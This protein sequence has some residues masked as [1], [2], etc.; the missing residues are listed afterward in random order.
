MVFSAYFGKNQHMAAWQAVMH[1]HAAWLGLVARIET[2]RLPHG[3]ICS[4]GWLQSRMVANNPA[5]RETQ[6]YLIIPTWGGITAEAR[7][8]AVE[9]TRQQLIAA[10]RSNVIQFGLSL[11]SGE[12]MVAVPPATPEQ[13]YYS[14][15]HRGWVFSNDMR[16]M[17][18]WAV[19]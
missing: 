12:L 5:L 1:R 10:M 11:Q 13:F 16:L 2:R 3:H 17:I 6:E 4:F 9:Q 19:L 15:D 8:S 7:T 18:R 14:K